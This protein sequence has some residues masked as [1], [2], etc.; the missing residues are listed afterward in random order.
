[1]KILFK[2]VFGSKLYSTDNETSDTDYKGIFTPTIQEC[3]LGGYARNINIKTNDVKNVKN[4]AED[5]DTELYALQ[6]FIKLALQGQTVAIDIL[7][8]PKDK[9]LISSPQWDVLQANK[10]RF[11]TKNMNSF[12]GYA[13][14]ISL[15]YESRA[16]K[17]NAFKDTIKF[18]REHNG[19]L[20]LKDIWDKLPENE[21]CKK[22]V[23]DNNF[24][25][26]GNKD[27]YFYEI[28]GKKMQE[29][30]SIDFVIELISIQIS[31]YGK[32]VREAANN[33]NF[34]S[35]GTSHAFRVAYE[36]KQILETGDLVFP[37]KETA[38]IKQVKYG[39]LNFINDKLGEKLE[40]LID[41][42]GDLIH[43][44]SLPDKPDKK[45]A[46]SFILACYEKQI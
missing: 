43:S 32:R 33:E 3:I 26:S 40:N 18:L 39:Q 29:F 6:E 30:A 1:M 27:R 23:Q 38:F 4:S 37:L 16:E 8:S 22:I 12:C 25:K 41:E 13:R 31:E 36:L 45:W 35:K 28:N 7:S 42:V 5:S 11:Y 19:S 17:L 34:D 46:D 24:E 15:K 9:I 10:K 21:F 44:S 20:L 2:G 14:A